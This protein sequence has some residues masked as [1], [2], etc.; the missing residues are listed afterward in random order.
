MVGVA[1]AVGL[2]LLVG[3]HTLVAAIVTRL[4]RVRLATRWTPIVF[5]LTIV[6]LLLI[7]ST[8]VIA[9]GLGVGPNLGSPGMALFALVVVPLGLGLA[10]DYLWMPAPDEVELPASL[11]P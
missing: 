10:I 4:L 8:L 3:L 2:V 11:E 7:G 5:A 6:P 9:G 1:A